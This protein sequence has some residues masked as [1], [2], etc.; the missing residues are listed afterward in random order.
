[1]SQPRSCQTHV[2]TPPGK[3]GSH[4]REGRDARATVRY[5]LDAHVDF[6][7]KDRGGAARREFGSTRDISHR[8][9]FILA[10]VCPSAGASVLLK[11]R[12]PTLLGETRRL[13]M[14]TEGRVLRVEPAGNGQ[15]GAGFAVASDRTALRASREPMALGDTLEEWQ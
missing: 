13:R 14:D 5:S 12:L 15:G 1:M 8:G 2:V 6:S 11:I 7:W 4:G 10:P 3:A 9:A